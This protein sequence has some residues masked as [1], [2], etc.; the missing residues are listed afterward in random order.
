MQV[1]CVLVS[2]GYMCLGVCV[3]VCVCVR[4]RARARAYVHVYKYKYTWSSLLFVSAL[5]LIIFWL[6]FKGKHI[7]VTVDVSVS[8]H[9][10]QHNTINLK[11]LRSVMINLS[12]HAQTIYYLFIYLFYSALVS[13]SEC[14][15]V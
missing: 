10:A 11:L 9:A 8:C 1:A 7:S 2:C 5:L 6:Q 15:S 14:I 12:K 3:C 4:A 13:L